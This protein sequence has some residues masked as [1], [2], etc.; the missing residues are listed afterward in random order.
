MR[1]QQAVIHLAAI[2]PPRSEIEPDHAYSVTVS[3]TRNV[4]N[5]VRAEPSRPRLIYVSSLAVF[6]RTSDRPPPRRVTDPVQPI[7]HYTRHKAEAESVVRAYEGAWAILRLG[8]V[9]PVGRLVRD[10]L[11]MREMFEIPLMQRIECVHAED[12]ARALTSAVSCDAVLG[13]I[14]LIGGGQRCQVLHRDFVQRAFE[15]I[16]IGALPAKAFSRVSYHTDWLDTDESER[17]LH[18]QRHSFED[19]LREMRRTIG[20][21][22]VVIQLLR[23]LVRWVVLRQSPYLS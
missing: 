15:E 10:P 21:A 17:L 20:P 18:Y 2:L 5:A 12:V 19:Y 6:G 1:G 8:M 14:P 9:V 4:V 13:R 16:G 11:L 23:P 7:D 3:G 22:R